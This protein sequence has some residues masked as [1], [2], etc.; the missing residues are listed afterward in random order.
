MATDARLN[1]SGWWAWMVD[2]CA[3]WATASA[4]GGA[5]PW[6]AQTLVGATVE[7]AGERRL[8]HDHL[9]KPRQE[10]PAVSH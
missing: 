10:L 7:G 9:K 4:A 1:Q 2:Q 5:G 8:I 3:V 6:P